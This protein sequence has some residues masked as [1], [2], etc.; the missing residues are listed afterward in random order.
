[1]A[2]PSPTTPQ[3]VSTAVSRQRWGPPPP[4]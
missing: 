4:R 1:V 2:T 3:R